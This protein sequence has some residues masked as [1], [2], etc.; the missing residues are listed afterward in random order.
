MI[1]SL[2][3]FITFIQHGISDPSFYFLTTV[4]VAPLFAP[5]L[6]NPFHLAHALTN[7]KSIIPCTLDIKT[8]NYQKWSH[9]FTIVV[10]R[11]S[12]K[13]I[14]DDD[15]RHSNISPDDWQRGDYLLQSWIYGTISDDLSSM[16]LSKSANAHD[17]WT[18]LAFLFTDNKDYRA[19]QLEEQFKSLKKDSLSIHEYCQLLKTTADSL[20]D[21]GH[22]ITD[23]QLVLQTLHGLPKP[24]GTIVNLISFQTPLPTFFQTR[25]LLQMEES[26]LD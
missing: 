9:F 6:P 1:P 13:P 25:S 19:I 16:I 22:P 10:G 12:L 11:F 8:P 26:R 4:T 23:K 24:Y 2:R 3:G 5:F 18:A 14:I 17:L 15:S 21:V 7:I 20:S